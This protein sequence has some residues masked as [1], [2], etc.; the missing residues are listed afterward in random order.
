MKD[1]ALKYF[2]SGLSVIPVGLDKIPTIKS[3]KERQSKLISPN[4]EFETA[5][6]IAVITG[7]IS[8]G[9]EC[10]DI[11]LKYDISGTLLQRFKDSIKQIDGSILKKLLVEKTTNGGYHFIYRYQTEE[12][13]DGN[14]KLASR[15]TTDERSEEHTSELQSH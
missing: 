3:W 9:L 11:D 8:G 5:K 13:R 6:G 4:G 1:I 15:Y 12:K 7:E 2:H 10:I 14:L